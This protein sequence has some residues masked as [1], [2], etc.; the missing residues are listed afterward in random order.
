[1]TDS[2]V[3]VVIGAF[4]E[5]PGGRIARTYGWSGSTRMVAYYFDTDEPRG[6][7]SVDDMADWI[8]R[9]DLFDFTDARDP[10]LPYVF[11]LHWDIK[12]MSELERVLRSA[13]HVD[14]DDI[15]SMVTE[16]FLP[17]DEAL[18]KAPKNAL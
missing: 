4:Y 8:L 9:K 16:Y 15:R 3:N 10:R 14:I 12:H 7:I 13:E 5:L 2:K 18:L 11:D 17:I 1:M 6:S